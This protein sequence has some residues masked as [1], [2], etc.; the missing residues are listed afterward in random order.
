MQE[1][2]FNS[3]VFPR[4]HSRRPLRLFHVLL[5]LIAVALP[6]RGQNAADGFDP[7]CNGRVFAIALQDDGKV[8]IGGEFTV[9]GGQPRQKLARLHA[10]GTIDITFNAE[11]NGS[12]SHQAVQRDGKILWECF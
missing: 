5:L 1:Q 4:C 2:L 12:I 7:N 9:V 6:G 11:A 8:V 10:D 3:M